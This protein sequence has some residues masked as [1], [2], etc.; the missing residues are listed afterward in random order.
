[1]G[2][3]H[4]SKPKDQHGIEIRP[5]DLIRVAI[6]RKNTV[7]MIVGIEDKTLKLTCYQWVLESRVPAG[8]MLEKVARLEDIS[9]YLEGTLTQ[10]EIIT[11]QGFDKRKKYAERYGSKANVR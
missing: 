3:Q 6:S 9:S 11:G 8:F 10:G 7:Y 4:T 5:G 2:T 1:M